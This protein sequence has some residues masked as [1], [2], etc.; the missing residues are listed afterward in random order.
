MTVDLFQ[1]SLDERDS[2]LGL[3]AV[4]LKLRLTRATETDTTNTLTGKVG[5]HPGQPGQTVLKLSQLDLQASFVGLGSA[6]E[7]IEDQGRAV[8][9]HDVQ[10]TLKVPL[11]AGREF[12]VDHD[13]VI[14]EVLAEVLD[15]LQLAL[16]DV[17]AGMWMRQPLGDGADDFNIDG[18]GQSREFLYGLGGIPG[19]GLRFDRDQQCFFDLAS[20]GN[21]LGA[22]SLL[23]FFVR[24]FGVIE[25]FAELVEFRL[26][27]V[28]VIV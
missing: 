3:P 22:M 26:D 19:L 15:L 14:V 18:L 17:G 5:P 4:G 23:E 27:N 20:G 8:D 13:E 21:E 2:L 24:L 1:L 7:D 16:P 6:G 12:A 28:I 11:L 9:D 25:L 10:I